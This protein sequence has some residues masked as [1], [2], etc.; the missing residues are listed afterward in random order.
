MT[1]TAN[2]VDRIIA[3]EDGEL[4]ADE[5]VALFQDL[6]DSG[7]VWSLQGSYHRTLRHLID[8]GLVAPKAGKGGAS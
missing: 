8:V 5:I 3:F 4:G 7:M 6:L 1:A 2:I